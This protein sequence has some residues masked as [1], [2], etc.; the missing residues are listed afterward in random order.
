VAIVRC[1]D[2][3]TLGNTGAFGAHVLASRLNLKRG[4]MHVKSYQQSGCPLTVLSRGGSSHN[5]SRQAS[6]RELRSSHA[7]WSAWNP[8]PKRTL[9]VATC[10]LRCMRH[11][12]SK[13]A[14]ASHEVATRAP[15]LLS[16]V[17]LAISVR[18]N[19][20][21]RYYPRIQR[22]DPPPAG[23]I[24][25]RGAASMKG[26]DPTTAC[27]RT[28]RRTL[29]HPLLCRSS[30]LRR[31]FRRRPRHATARTTQLC[32]SSSTVRWVKR[33]KRHD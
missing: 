15:I 13:R 11:G 21:L 16:D 23:R 27:L 33:H 4:H 28:K 18:C 12:N 31:S 1:D 26:L 17:W 20:F 29:T 7:G 25:K 2:R 30:S 8:C 22:G 32:T 3:I 6:A 9:G 10:A 5:C 24:C 19:W 14:V